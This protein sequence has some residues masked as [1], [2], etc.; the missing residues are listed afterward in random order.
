MEFGSSPLNAFLNTI[1]GAMLEQPS[2]QEA[3][4]AQASASNDTTDGDN[5]EL[6]PTVQ[7]SPAEVEMAEQ[8]AAQTVEATQDQTI[9]EPNDA[10][11]Q[12]ARKVEDEPMQDTGKVAD[13]PSAVR[14]QQEPDEHAEEQSDSA[15][16]SLQSLL[17]RNEFDDEETQDR[18]AELIDAAIQMEDAVLCTRYA[19]CTDSTCKTFMTHYSHCKDNQPCTDD[20]CQDA[21]SYY[22]HG[23]TCSNELCPFCVR[24]EC[25]AMSSMDQMD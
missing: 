10:P 14:G 15:P 17:E 2:S 1:D 5:V 21:M 8:P 23:N 7:E 13:E 18:L 16:E 24:G 11:T 22:R 12:E 9:A 25:D 20:H 6:L 3:E 19:R 4:D